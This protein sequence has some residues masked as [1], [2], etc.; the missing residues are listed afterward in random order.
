VEE[1]LAKAGLLAMILYFPFSF[2]VLSFH[3]LYFDGMGCVHG[4]RRTGLG[5][6]EYLLIW[7]TGGLRRTGMVMD[8]YDMDTD[9]DTD[10]DME[11][12]V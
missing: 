7:R 2:L 11:G 3:G 5:L 8:I 12:Y 4:N 6:V 9:M 1:A 10:M